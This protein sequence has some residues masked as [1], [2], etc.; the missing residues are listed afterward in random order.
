MVP[1]TPMRERG[2]AETDSQ[3]LVMSDWE[4]GLLPVACWQKK[5]GVLSLQYERQL[6]LFFL[7]PFLSLG[8]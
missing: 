2:K 7:F 1:E 6:G 4:S 8:F 5:D 3:V